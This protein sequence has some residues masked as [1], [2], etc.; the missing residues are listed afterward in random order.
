MCK[1][2]TANKRYHHDN[3]TEHKSTFNHSPFPRLSCPA[4]DQ[5]SSGRFVTKVIEIKGVIHRIWNSKQTFQLVTICNQL[6]VH[7]QVMP[8]YLLLVA[9][10]LQP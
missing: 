9:D 8:V 3:K 4:S 5:R 1:Q 7:H 10:S 2:V 6:I